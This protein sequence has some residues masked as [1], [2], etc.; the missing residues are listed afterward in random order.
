M[1]KLRYAISIGL[2]V[3]T[4]AL[5]LTYGLGAEA[6][7][8]TPYAEPA[9]NLFMSLVQGGGHESMA[10]LHGGGT[11]ERPMEEQ[12]MSEAQMRNMNQSII[13]NNILGSPKSMAAG[14]LAAVTVM[15]VV[16][17]GAA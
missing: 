16:P 6:I 9:H 1:G 12:D 13:A 5:V 7:L 3:V 14:G 2:A 11:N 8:Q 17:L 15:G 10:R 4:L